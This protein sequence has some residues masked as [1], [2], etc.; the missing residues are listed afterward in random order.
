MPSS[1]RCCWT[2][3]RDDAP[4]DL[5]A[6]LRTARADTV[7]VTA[8]HQVTPQRLRRLAWQL[9]GT[10]VNLIVAPSLTDV[11]GPRISVRP[12]GGLPLLHVDEPAFTGLSRVVK[13]SMDRLAALLGLLALS[14]ILLAVAF[15]VRITSP[16]YALFRQPRTGAH[17]EQFRVFKFRTMYRDAEARQAGTHRAERARRAPVQDEER[18]A[19]HTGRALPAAYVARRAAA[20]RQRAASVRCHSSGRAPCPWTTRSSRATYA[21]ASRAAPASPDCGR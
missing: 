2:S 5:L 16:G 21:A 18:P 8:V 13:H 4:D 9:E 19:D 10:G 14:P 17:G 6:A 12:V 1:E 3:S 20:A 7:A 15:A 11:A